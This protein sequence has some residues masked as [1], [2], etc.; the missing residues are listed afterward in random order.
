MRNI[1]GGKIE[2]SIIE[3]NWPTFW[4]FIGSLQMNL[5]PEFV[6]LDLRPDLKNLRFVGDQFIL[7]DYDSFGTLGQPL[8][9]E[10]YPV[11][12]CP[13]RFTL[14]QALAGAWAMLNNIRENEI[15][16][17]FWRATGSEKFKQF[18]EYYNQSESLIDTIDEAA[19]N[20]ATPAL[21]KEEFNDLLI[22]AK[23]YLFTLKKSEVLSV[24]S[25]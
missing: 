9:D 5:P 15:R 12:K 7:L 14:A 6:Y 11:T 25:C 19:S 1:Q 24:L 20:E 4:S 18:R 3:D 2:R 16:D 22:E 10:R 8:I 17:G 13:R 23:T 21:T